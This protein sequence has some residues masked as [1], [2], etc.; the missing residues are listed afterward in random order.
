MKIC[1]TW[2]FVVDSSSFYFNSLC[3]AQGHLETNTVWSKYMFKIL[4]TVSEN[5][6]K[7]YKVCQLFVLLH[8]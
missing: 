1:E 3:A 8:S 4:L 6:P 2:K 5:I 7:S